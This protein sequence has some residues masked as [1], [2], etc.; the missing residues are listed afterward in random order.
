MNLRGD[1]ELLQDFSESGN[2]SALEELIRRHGGM[3]LGVC[4]RFTMNPQDAQDA[5]QATFLTLARKA[6]TL[7][8]RPSIAGWLYQVA[9]FTSMRAHTSETLRKTRENEANQDIQ[10]AARLE[11]FELSELRQILD[12]ELSRL[13]EKFRAP[14]ILCYLEERTQEEAAQLL[15][16][17]PRTLSL[18]LSQARSILSKRLLHRG[19]ALSG[20]GFLTLLS[21]NA[22]AAPTAEFVKST[23]QVATQ[24][25]ISM[26][27]LISIKA[28]HLSQSAIYALAFSK[29]K[30][31][32]IYMAAVGLLS[33]LAVAGVQ[34]YS[35][36]KTED[37]TR[38][39]FIAAKAG[40]VVQINELVTNQC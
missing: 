4:Q 12:L 25:S 34:T 8:D 32:L 6:K 15:G 18:Y 30:T 2:E 27:G 29:V 40:D 17:H 13:P 28:Q 21:S 31:A 1:G 24:S 7:R 37:L 10:A 3:V 35:S 33:F 39:L 20:A 22:S 26:T 5:A 19:I 14:M 16:I 9:R 23:M 36:T 11:R 38:A